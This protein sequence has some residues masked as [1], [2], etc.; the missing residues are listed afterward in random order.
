[1]KVE[2]Q[3][4]CVCGGRGEVCACV[5]NC[6]CESERGA[7]S[8]ARHQGRDQ[9]TWGIDSVRGR[10]VV[11]RVRGKVSRS[12]GPQVAAC[13]ACQTS[14]A[15][16]VAKLSHVNTPHPQVC[17]GPQTHLEHELDVVRRREAHCSAGS[18]VAQHTMQDGQQRRKGG[19][20]DLKQGAAL[21]L[22]GCIRSGRG[23]GQAVSR[24]C[25]GQLPLTLHSQALPVG[26]MALGAVN[27]QPHCSV[28]L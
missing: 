4:T 17:V 3:N 27:C 14:T 15:A 5:C 20:D 12:R 1:M 18:G 21:L 9:N 10:G 8:S 28:F 7:C 6:N 25:S 2:D 16:V 23:S 26:C 24:C 22:W 11:T 13:E 19:V